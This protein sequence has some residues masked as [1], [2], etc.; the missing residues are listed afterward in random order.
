MKINSIKWDRSHEI[1]Q[2]RMIVL[3]SDGKPQHRSTTEPFKKPSIHHILNEDNR[4]MSG[5]RPV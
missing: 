5:D 4:E 3:Q 1:E 2:H